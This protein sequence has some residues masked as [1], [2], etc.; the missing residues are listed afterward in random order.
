MKSLLFT[1]SSVIFPQLPATFASA[2]IANASKLSWKF[3]SFEASCLNLSIFSANGGV[4]DAGGFAVSNFVSVV[5]NFLNGLKF[6]SSACSDLAG[7]YRHRLFFIDN[8]GGLHR[9]NNVL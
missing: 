3:E 9:L 6:L 1:L 5:L 2:H 4:L 7:S 8:N